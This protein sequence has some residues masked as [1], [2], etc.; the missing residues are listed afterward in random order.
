MK[1]IILKF[2][3]I[4]VKCFIN[5]ITVLKII[6]LLLFSVHNKILNVQHMY[7]NCVSLVTKSRKAHHIMCGWGIA[8]NSNVMQLAKLHIV[9]M[10]TG[11]TNQIQAKGKQSGWQQQRLGCKLGVWF[12]IIYFGVF[13]IWIILC[14]AMVYGVFCQNHHKRVIF[15]A[16]Q[17]FPTLHV[18]GNGYRFG[19]QSSISIAKSD[20]HLM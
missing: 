2:M 7:R 5:K 17:T 3:V 13:I 12:M 15:M 4:S 14:C 10:T 19:I 6:C 18:Y 8:I 11:L 16:Y 1:R 9:Y 20:N